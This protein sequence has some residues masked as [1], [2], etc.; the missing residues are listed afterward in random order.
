LQ[1]T[2]LEAGAGI[3]SERD[4]NF[5]IGVSPSRRWSPRALEEWCAN[6]VPSSLSLDPFALGAERLC[7][8]HDGDISISIPEAE[9][10]AVLA[11]L[12]QWASPCGVTLELQAAPEAP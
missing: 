10:P 1:S 11:A 3:Y 8:L 7:M 5:W 12:E 6:A 9:A 2:V 4:P